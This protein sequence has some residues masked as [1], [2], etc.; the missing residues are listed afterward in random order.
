MTTG[1]T[2]AKDGNRH[3]NNTSVF[4][5]SRRDGRS[6]AQ[7]ILDMVQGEE[8]ERVFTY[9]EIIEALQQNTNRTFNVETARSAVYRSAHRLL[10]EQARA[11]QNVH[12][13][14]YRL[15]PACD[16]QKIALV[17]KQRADVQLKQGLHML[18]HVRWDEMDE[19][20]RA[21]H[22]GTL[23]IVAALHSNQKAI[24]DRLAR[25]EKTIRESRNGVVES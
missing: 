7:V 19:G 15:A 10:K 13:V 12:N 4:E 22:Q 11:L 24:N 3:R 2:A 25:I 23:M 16:H 8:P 17:R 6:D 21:A 9:H 20:A 14:G 5:T 18:E 1:A